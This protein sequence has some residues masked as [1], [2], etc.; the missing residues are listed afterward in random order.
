MI[1][2]ADEF[3]VVGVER[4]TVTVPAGRERVTHPIDEAQNRALCELRFVGLADFEMPFVSV[5]VSD[6]GKRVELA[7]DEPA[8]FDFDVRITVIEWGAK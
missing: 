6:D 1:I 5:R 3:K 8:D 4:F 7:L 2:N